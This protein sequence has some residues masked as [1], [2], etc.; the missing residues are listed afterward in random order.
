MLIIAFQLIWPEGHMEPR[1]DVGSLSPTEHL[2]GFEP[3]T[4]GF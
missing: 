4:F 3:G 2:V 1:N